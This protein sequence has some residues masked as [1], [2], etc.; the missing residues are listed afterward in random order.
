MVGWVGQLKICEVSWGDCEQA[1]HVSG[2]SGLMKCMYEFSLG[3]ELLRSWARRVLWWRGSEVSEGWI[4]G[5]ASI[6]DGIWDKG[7]DGIV[8]HVCMDE[9]NGQFGRGGVCDRRG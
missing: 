5:G 1:G 4:S 3:Q 6:K 2:M 8:G 7:L 9:F